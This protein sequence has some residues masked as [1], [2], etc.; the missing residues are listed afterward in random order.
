MT[1]P[2]TTN[3]GNCKHYQQDKKVRSMGGCALHRQATMRM[4]W[5]QKH[6]WKEVAKSA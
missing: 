3:C 5:C 4:S 2:I 6:D 1:T